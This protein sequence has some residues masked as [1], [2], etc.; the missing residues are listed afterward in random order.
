MLE[1]KVKSWLEGHGYPLELRVANVLRK[2]DISADHY[3]VYFDPATGKNREIDL[4]GY[5]DHSALSIHLVFE[6]KHSQ[7]KPWILFCTAHRALTPEGFV[8]SVPS[9]RMAR[10]IVQYLAGD[11]SVQTMNMFKVPDLVGFRLIRAFTDNQDTAYHAVLGLASACLLTADTIGRYN[12]RVIYVPVV[13]IDSPLLIC[14]LPDDGEEIE[15]SQASQGLLLH[16][17][18][19]RHVIIHVLHVDA[20][21]DFVAKSKEDAVIFNTKAAKAPNPAAQADS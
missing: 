3:R 1:Q 18:G 4:M 10:E 12:H 14:H 17:S 13:V 6:C 16:N 9:T 5:L 2:A 7:D 8:V 20:L 19:D 15:L 21:A 11:Q